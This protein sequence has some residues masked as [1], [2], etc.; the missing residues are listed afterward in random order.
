MKT[1]NLTFR[2]QEY[3]VKAGMT[4]YHALQNLG[5]DEHSVIPTR[6]GEVLT[7]DEILHDGD[8]IKL[9]AVISGG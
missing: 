6:D 7:D 4:I 8:V 2:K 3:E 9:V 5:I 1:A